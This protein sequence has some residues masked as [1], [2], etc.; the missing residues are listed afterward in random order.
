LIHEFHQ[1]LQQEKEHYD[2]ERTKKW[3]GVGLQNV[4]IYDHEPMYKVNSSFP[5]EK[6]KRLWRRKALTSAAFFYIFRQVQKRP[7]I[8]TKQ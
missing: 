4:S 5:T 2:A 7:L 6:R 1:K 3:S 8:E